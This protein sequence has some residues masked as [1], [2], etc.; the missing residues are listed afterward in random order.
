VA[1]TL[2]A[3]V[4]QA[5]LDVLLRRDTLVDGAEVARAPAGHL[6]ADLAAVDQALA[7]C[8][9]LLRNL[10]RGVAQ[11]D[12]DDVRQALLVQVAQLCEQ[13]RGL[14]ADRERLLAEQAA[15]EAQQAR[16]AGVEAW[17]AAAAAQLEHLRPEQRRQAVEMLGVEVRL[18]APAAAERWTASARLPSLDVP[19]TLRTCR[20]STTACTASA[21]RARAW[22]R[23]TR[24]TTASPGNTAANRS[25]SSSAATSP[26]RSGCPAATC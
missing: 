10:T 5:V 23:S 12:D 2:D 13:G 26:A 11:T 8:E 7:E 3:D 9:R 20:S 22:S 15:W 21:C 6:A 24:R 17:M 18:F 14:A 1:E 19:F 4:W 25:S 16:W